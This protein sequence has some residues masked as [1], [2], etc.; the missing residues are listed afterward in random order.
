MSA[1]APLIRLERLSKAYRLG[2]RELAIL[3]ELDLTVQPGEFISIMGASGSG[4]STLLNLLGCLDRPSAGQ[5]CFAGAEV[6]ALDD[7]QLSRMRSAQ[8]GFVFQAF[9]LLPHLSV[10]ENV[11]LPF[12][13][14]ERPPE[15]L[16]ERV[17]T[18]LEQVGLS[19]RRQHRPAELSGGEM[20]RVA[21]ARAIVTRPSLI[22]ADE[23]TGSLDSATGTDILAILER[24]NGAGTTLVLVTHDHGVAQRAQRQLV[25]RDGRF[26]A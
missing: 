14:A 21:I 4:K 3:H 19:A 23:P 13:Y 22:L 25:L 1:P 20:Q 7:T 10:F 11:A 24:L 9:H 17:D 6:A 15:Q 8:I 12:Q 18:A 16:A 2:G 26:A 5:Y